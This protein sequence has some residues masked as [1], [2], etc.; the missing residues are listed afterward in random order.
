MKSEIYQFIKSKS[1]SATEQGRE[2]KE[3]CGSIVG[4]E[5]GKQQIWI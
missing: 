1:E 2:R 3:S 4:L 5:T